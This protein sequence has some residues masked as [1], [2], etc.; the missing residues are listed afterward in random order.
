MKPY[1]IFDYD[2]TLVNSKEMWLSAFKEVMKKFGHEMRNED[3]KA[4]MG[5][6]TKEMIAL[7]L[8]ENEKQKAEL[9]KEMIDQIVSSEKGLKLVNLC[10]NA[11]ETITALK[12]KG[13]KMSLVT[14]SDAAFV[15]A[16]LKRFQIQ[17]GFWDLIITADDPFAK[18][19][20]S[21]KFLT[22]ALELNNGIVY[23]A[24]K[25]SDAALA[26]N[27]GVKSVIIA[28]AHSWDSEEK[29]MAARPD[30]L[31]HDLKELPKLL[32]KSL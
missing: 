19:E 24:D 30:F 3:I 11:L 22:E 26:K 25:A 17:D 23:I 29:I 4:R 31:I 20:D 9:G 10:S 5:P 28:S 27:A 15:F 13:Y 32:T 2:G 18:K 6:K 8:P 14:N 7:C 21:F 1:L 16:S 12:K